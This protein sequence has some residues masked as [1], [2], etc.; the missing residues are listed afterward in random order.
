M[1]RL[2]E[3]ELTGRKFGRLVVCGL[4][5]GLWVCMC[6]CGAETFIPTSNLVSG[7]TTS[8][9]CYHAERQKQV[10]LRHGGRYTV[11]Y[12]RWLNMWQRCANPKNP[13]WK[14]YG[15]RGIGV[16]PVWKSFA[17]FRSDMGEPPDSLTLERKN[18]NGHYSKENCV[19]AT[20]KT[21]TRNKRT[22]RILTFRGQAMSLIEWAESLKKPYWTLHSRLRRG[23]SVERTLS[24]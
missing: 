8:C 24:T 7:N 16:D 20:I 4:K 21:Q 1:G 3:Y 6:S 5:D 9:G 18:V 17:Q 23:W 11:L 12:A 10:P 19:W 2:R 22:N 15:G 14:N 13:A